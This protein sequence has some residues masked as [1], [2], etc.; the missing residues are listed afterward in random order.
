M[1]TRQGSVGMDQING[2]LA[3]QVSYLTFQSFK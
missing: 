1:A 3:M 2:L